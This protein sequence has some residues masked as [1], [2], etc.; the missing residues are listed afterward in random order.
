MPGQPPCMMAFGGGVMPP[1]AYVAGVTA[2]QYGMPMTG[3]PIGLPGPPHVPLGVPAGLQRHTIVNHTH[4]EL[5]EP[6]RNVRIDVKQK[7]G[8]QLSGAGQPGLDRGEGQFQPRHYPQPMGERHQAI[9]TGVAAPAAP[10]PAG[11]DPPMAGG[12]ASAGSVMAASGATS[13]GEAKIGN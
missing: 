10:C 1:P 8:H 11:G 9:G 6:T 2:P 7:P 4:V 5:P 12:A 3:T 13:A